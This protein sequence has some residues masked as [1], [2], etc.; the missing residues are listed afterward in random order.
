MKVTVCQLRTPSG[1]KVD[2][3]T[4]GFVAVSYRPSARL[5]LVTEPL[6]Q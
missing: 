2:M 3:L 4:F 5:W 6:L 1:G